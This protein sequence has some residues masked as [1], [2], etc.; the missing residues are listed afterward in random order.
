MDESDDI[1]VIQ[2]DDNEPK[3]Q[4]ENVDNVADGFQSSK[5]HK[6][7][8]HRKHHKHSSHHHH[9]EELIEADKTDIKEPPKQIVIQPEP[10]FSANEVSH[11][12]AIN[13]PFEFSESSNTSVIEVGTLINGQIS[14]PNR[15]NRLFSSPPKPKNDKPKQSPSVFE[16]LHFE[17]ESKSSTKSNIYASDSKANFKTKNNFL[18]SEYSYEISK[19]AFDRSHKNNQNQD[20]ISNQNQNIDSISKEKKKKEEK[21]K[22]AQLSNIISSNPIIQSDDNFSFGPNDF[23]SSEEIK[24]ADEDLQHQEIAL[25]NISNGSNQDFQSDHNSNSNNSDFQ[26]DHSSKKYNFK[27]ESPTLSAADQNEENIDEEIKQ[28]KE[29][30]TPK[31]E[32]L[33]QEAEYVQPSP[34]ISFVNYNSRPVEVDYRPKDIKLTTSRKD[35]HTSFEYKILDSLDRALNHIG[36]EFIDDFQYY[37]KQAFSYDSLYDEFIMN[38]KADI[39]NIFHEFDSVSNETGIVS[40]T[41]LTIEE[42]FQSLYGTFADIKTGAPSLPIKTLNISKDICLANE[43]IMKNFQTL[44]EIRSERSNIHSVHDEENSVD[45]TLKLQQLLFENIELNVLADIQRE[46]MNRIDELLSHIKEKKNALI[47]ENYKAKFEK[48]DSYSFQNLYNGLILDLQDIDNDE[49]DVQLRKTLQKV[50]SIRGDLN[51]SKS[52]MNYLS[53]MTEKLDKILKMNQP[54]LFNEI[55]RYQRNFRESNYAPK[56]IQQE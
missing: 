27:L 39:V 4:I 34:N 18:D 56:Y 25:T 9:K 37:V 20:T 2:S 48:D 8:R 13:N 3:Q 12:E 28:S 21:V 1:F 7:R 38:L 31:K 44:N 22:N 46:R 6:R 54:S 52:N 14:S 55:E 26:S 15:I 11:E 23:E 24:I 47:S 33:E 5:H 16:V 29:I 42:N 50:K 49:D 36:Q 53:D 41:K 30:T 10:S 40:N 51:E 45:F 43:K 32:Q 35:T 17:D 19:E